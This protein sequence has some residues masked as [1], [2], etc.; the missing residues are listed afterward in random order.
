MPL[1]SSFFKLNFDGSKLKDG[2]TSF[3]FVIRDEKGDLKLCGAKSFSPH[4]SILVVE[5]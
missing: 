5:A 4:H 2:A 3:G 1:P